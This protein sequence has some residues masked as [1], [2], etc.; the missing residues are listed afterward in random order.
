MHQTLP[1][2]KGKNEKKK[3]NI[4]LFF[5]VKLG[6]GIHSAFKTSNRSNQLDACP[7]FDS[8]IRNHTR[9][10]SNCL[11]RKRNIRRDTT[12]YWTRIHRA[13]WNSSSSSRRYKTTLKA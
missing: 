2:L 11:V 7:Y 4:L 10:T 12:A 5:L 8:C 13:F 9:C 3:K 6:N 1:L